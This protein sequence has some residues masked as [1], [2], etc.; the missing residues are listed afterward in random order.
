MRQV[1]IPTALVSTVRATLTSGFLFLA[2]LVALQTQLVSSASAKVTF[3]NKWGSGGGQMIAV[4][5]TV[6]VYVL[7]ADNHI[8]RFDVDGSYQMKFGGSG[9]DQF[10][11]PVRI[12]VSDTGHIY[13]A[14]RNNRI[15][16]FDADGNYQIKWNI[17]FQEPVHIAISATGQ[18]YVVDDRNRIRRF[19]ADG[20]YQM[21]FDGTG[22]GDGQFQDPVR[23]A[24]S[25]TGHIYVANGNYR[26]QRFDADG[27]YQ[28]KWNMTL[29]DNYQDFKFIDASGTGQVY[30]TTESHG[31]AS[32][33]FIHRF[34]AD[35][36][37]QM[38]WGNYGTGDGQFQD[39]P[40]DITVSNTG[41]V[42]VTESG[43]IHNFFDSEA[44]FSGTNT[45]VNSGTGPTSVAVGPGD[46]LGASLTLDAS[47][48]LVV[49]DTTTVNSG[50]SLSLSGGTLNTPNLLLNG[51]ALLNAAGS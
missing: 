30:L 41:H 25:D 29:Y 28:I 20:N 45:F 43:K 23:I 24:V 36:N 5:D 39:E 51:G 12:A 3:L 13:V 11:G 34:D 47:K 4:S 35:G 17:K 44:W 27:N 2:F 42:Y 37:H 32:H 10:Q 31:D 22:S 1:T 9:D 15:Q 16:R 49:G 8:Q 38:Q 46:I 48:G 40:M 33:A 18:V 26:I 50:G 19:D 14:D 21:L 7:D 6:Q